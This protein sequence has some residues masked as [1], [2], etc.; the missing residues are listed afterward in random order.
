[1]PW[2]RGPLPHPRRFDQ[3][4]EKFDHLLVISK[5]RVVQQVFGPLRVAGPV[6]VV[7]GTGK[8]V[9]RVTGAAFCRCGQSANKPYCDGSHARVGFQAPGV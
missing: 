5:F 8:T 9:N 3:A 4:R 6:E 1:M 7:T 2:R